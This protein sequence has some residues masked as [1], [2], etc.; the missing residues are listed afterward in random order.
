MNK[1]HHLPNT[2]LLPFSEI[3]EKQ[4]TLLISST[5]AGAAVRGKLHGL[6][7][8]AA[9]KK[10]QKSARELNQAAQAWKTQNKRG[11]YAYCHGHQPA[12]R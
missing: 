4:P 6:N 10:L 9:L 2:C 12:R 3:E 11:E 5:P 8:V 7:I 1:I